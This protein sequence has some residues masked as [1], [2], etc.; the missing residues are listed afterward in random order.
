MSDLS[1]L[2]NQFVA[3]LHKAQTFLCMRGLQRLYDYPYFFC[4]VMKDFFKHLP[5]LFSPSFA[6]SRCHFPHLY[7]SSL[8]FIVL[9]F[10]SPLHLCGGSPCKYTSAD[11]QGLPVCTASPPSL[12]I[13]LTKMCLLI[14]KHRL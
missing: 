9:R 13:I 4:K 8:L 3:H 14:S 2:M 10:A 6:A 12:C 1:V 5:P 11:S 7:K